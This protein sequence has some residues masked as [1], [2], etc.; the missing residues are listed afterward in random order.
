MG[1]SAQVNAMNIV[2]PPDDEWR[3]IANLTG[4]D[5]W[6]PENVRSNYVEMERNVYLPNGTADHGFDGYVSVRARNYLRREQA[7]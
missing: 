3:I 4:D 2:L 1:G 7:L 5:S 6:L